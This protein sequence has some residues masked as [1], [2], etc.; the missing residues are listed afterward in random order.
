MTAAPKVSGAPG[1]APKFKHPSAFSRMKH[2]TAAAKEDELG[3]DARSILLH[4]GVY[5]DLDGLAFPSSTRLAEDSGYSERAVRKALRDLREAGVVMSLPTAAWK[6]AFGDRAK[7]PK[8]LP[9][10]LLWPAAT[11][12]ARLK[13]LGA[14]LPDHRKAITKVDDSWGHGVRWFATPPGAA[15]QGPYASESVERWARTEA[16]AAAWKIRMESQPSEKATA[17]EC[18]DHL[19]ALLPRVPSWARGE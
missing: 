3:K 11:R 5:M 12:L 15:E 13:A 16:G 14:I 19:G 6:V 17:L 7:V 1:A 2:L 8:H 18:Y 9:M 4:I 10:L